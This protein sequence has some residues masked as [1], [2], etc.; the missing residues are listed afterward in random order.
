M[1]Y[2]CNLES[3]VTARKNGLVKDL[4]LLKINHLTDA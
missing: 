3:A 4:V 1:P 2:P